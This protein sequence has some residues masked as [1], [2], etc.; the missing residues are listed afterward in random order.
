[1]RE[2]EAQV[3][4]VE[5][6]IAPVLKFLPWFALVAAILGWSLGAIG[7]AMLRSEHPEEHVVGFFVIYGGFFSLAAVIASIPNAVLGPRRNL[8]RVVGS[9]ALGFI[10]VVVAISF[11]GRA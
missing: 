2:P 1:M 3:A 7:L 6:G 9:F 4:E 5:S 10:L 11:L 8:S